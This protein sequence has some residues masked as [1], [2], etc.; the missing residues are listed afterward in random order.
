MAEKKREM[1]Y[2]YHK[3]GDKIVMDRARHTEHHRQAH[4]K[5][6]LPSPRYVAGT[7]TPLGDDHM[8]R[9]EKYYEATFYR[10]HKSNL[11]EWEEP[12]RLKRKRERREANRLKREGAVKRG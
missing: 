5:L 2:L 9:L 10:S 1:W 8:A 6:G 4:A 7:Q 12:E 11:P 3:V